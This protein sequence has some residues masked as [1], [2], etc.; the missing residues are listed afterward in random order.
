MNSESRARRTVFD[1]VMISKMDDKTGLSET[2]CTLSRNEWF[3]E[4]GV[5]NQ[6]PRNASVISRAPVVLLVFS[7][8]VCIYFVGYYSCLCDSRYRSQL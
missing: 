8:V 3:G 5:I 6:A 7:D 2:R 4:V 1:A